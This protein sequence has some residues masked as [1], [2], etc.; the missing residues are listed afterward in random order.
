M[1][2]S[3]GICLELACLVGSA[4]TAD[5]P[6]NNLN[7]CLCILAPVYKTADCSAQMSRTHPRR[8]RCAGSAS[9]RGC[10]NNETVILG[11]GIGR[12]KLCMPARRFSV[13][14]S[15]ML[16]IRSEARARASAWEKPPTT[17]T[18]SRVSP[19]RSRASSI[20]PFASPRRDRRIC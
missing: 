1:A 19:N 3:S 18:F 13:C 16:A 20:G 11:I 9:S 15:G 7:C 14:R 4:Q 17:V 6:E 12:A 2:M 10:Q 5:P 8:K